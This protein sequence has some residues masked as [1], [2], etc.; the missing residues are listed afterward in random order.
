M[1]FRAP[2]ILSALMVLFTLG[3][4]GGNPNNKICDANAPAPYNKCAEATAPCPAGQTFV[5]GQCRIPANCP[6]GYTKSESGCQPRSFACPPGEHEDEVGDCVTDELTVELSSRSVCWVEQ[7]EAT[8]VIVQYTVR[9]QE[10]RN[11]ATTLDTTGSRE[12]PASFF[13]NGAPLDVEAQISSDSELLKSDLVLSLV[14]DASYSMLTHEPPAFEPMKRAAV[15]ILR[16]TQTLWAQR[17]GSQFHWQLLWFDRLLNIPTENMAGESWAIDD[18]ARI[19]DPT[20]G[21]YTALYKAINKMVATH[22]AMYERGIAAGSRDQHVMLILS[23]GA[24]NQWYVENAEEAEERN[25]DMLYW[26]REGGAATDID[27]VKANVQSTPY[28]R[29]HVIGFGSSVDSDS[30]LQQSLKDIASAG[31]GQYFF[32]VDTNTLGELF[33]EVQTEFVTLQT[34]GAEAPLAPG[35]YTFSLIVEHPESGAEGT[36]E[37]TVTAGS[38]VGACDVAAP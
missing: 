25:I 32:G 15:E 30:G 34:L 10:G 7:S 23:D 12:L 8:R 1:Y 16:E 4:E 33:R 35:E 37:F 6:A 13:I 38:E 29:T 2:V 28:L 31:R 24:D 21:A 14:L 9:D 20:K 27:E 26:T 36:T 22:E 5:G 11:L 18:I 19:P 3:C 17:E